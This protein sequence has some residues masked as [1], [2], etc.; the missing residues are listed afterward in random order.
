MALPAPLSLTIWSIVKDEKNPAVPMPTAGDAAHAVAKGALSGIPYVGGVAAE[1]FGIV[2]APPLSKRR[3]A[4]LESLAERLKAAEAKLESLGEDPAFVTTALQAT[5]IALRTHQEEK[6][7]A[8]RNAVANSVSGRGPEDDTRAM[9]LSLVDSFTPTHL[10]L[11]KYFQNRHSVDERTV[12]KLMFEANELTNIMVEELAS[13]GLLRDE[14]PYAA[15][16]RGTGESLLNFAWT[17]S[18]LGTRF[19]QFISRPPAPG[20]TS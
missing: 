18:P 17:V 7:D 13:N 8:L 9:F 4:W 10:L 5:Q 2:L 3:D 20:K 15:R 14:R 16:G 6:L 1:L 11:L 12:R 19:L